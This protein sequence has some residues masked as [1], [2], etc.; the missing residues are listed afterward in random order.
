MLRFGELDS[1]ALRVVDTMCAGRPLPPLMPATR[2]LRPSESLSRAATERMAAY[3]HRVLLQGGGQRHRTV[4]RQGRRVAGRLWNADLNDGFTLTFT[5]ACHDAWLGTVRA[6]PEASSMTWTNA[7]A[8]GFGRF[9]PTR[10]TATGDWV[11]YALA[12]RHLGDQVSA[13]REARRG[14][15]RMLAAGSPLARLMVL[16]SVSDTAR[17]NPTPKRAADRSGAA[18]FSALFDPSAVR[19]IECLE[20]FIVGH[21]R[22]L[23][24]RHSQQPGAFWAPAGETLSAFVD[25]A[26]IAERLDLTRG[27]MTLLVALSTEVLPEEPERVRRRFMHSLD[28]G[29]RAGERRAALAGVAAVLAT[30][31]RLRD[32]REGVAGVG[33]GDPRYEEIQ[34]F[35]G[36]YDELLAPHLPRIDHLIRLLTG[37][38]G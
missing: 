9:V 20:S 27:V 38:I 21:W 15:T 32:L 17:S 2:S 35:K 10:R 25:A 3:A 36:N 7:Q 16:R 14:Y 13:L 26:D 33:Y 31:R 30:G 4:L 24:T 37:A 18:R 6:L 28:V 23:V 19:L 5:R 34:I 29:A 1:F 22:S 8:D 11:V 12:A